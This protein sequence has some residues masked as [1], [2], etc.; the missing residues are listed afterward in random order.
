MGLGSDDS[1]AF[2]VAPAGSGAKGEIRLTPK[3]VAAPGKAANQDFASAPAGKTNPI[4]LKP[5]ASAQVRVTGLPP[6][7]PIPAP[8][9]V[10]P[11]NPTQAKNDA[12]ISAPA[13]PINTPRAIDTEEW[14]RLPSGGSLALRYQRWAKRVS[15]SARKLDFPSQCPCCMQ[16]ADAEYEAR[17]AKMRERQNT[18]VWAFPYCTMCLGHLRRAWWMRIAARILG[19]VA[20]LV[21]AGVVYLVGGATAAA[22]AGAI[23]GLAAWIPTE[24]FLLRRVAAGMASSCACYGPAV[25]FAEFYG[26]VQH[27]DFASAAY[28]EAFQR[29]NEK[30]LV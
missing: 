3:P 28:A 24:R 8:P 6:L 15:V 19:V 17:V 7:K 27:F 14:V 30:K 26:S 12:R 5:A 21:L 23:A 25:R 4:D 20:A 22:V 16:A 1:G 18:A 29:M 13:T 9:S 2:R 11:A 10:P